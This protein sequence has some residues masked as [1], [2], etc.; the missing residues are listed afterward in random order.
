MEAIKNRKKTRR[1][2][3]CFEPIVMEYNDS[4][5]PG[6][7]DGSSDQVY[8]YITVG[9]N[10]G[11]GGE[12][13]VPKILSSFSDKGSN[14]EAVPDGGRKKKGKFSRVVRAV[15]FE[16]YLSKKIRSRKS[17][18]NSFR[19]SSS[20]SSKYDKNSNSVEEKSMPRESPEEVDD[21]RLNRNTS[22]S[23]SS[24]PSTIT[25]TGGSPSLC[26][27]CSTCSRS[28][29]GRK[30]S[31]RSNSIYLK[32]RNDDGGR[33]YGLCLL[34][35]SLLVLIF[36]GKVCAI[37]CT[38]TWLFFL[39][40][41]NLGYELPEYGGQSPEMDTVGYKKKIIMEGLLERNRSKVL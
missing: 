15:L 14:N 27:S 35:I 7:G 17:R 36:W 34:L 33:I 25:T 8:A 29:S 5:K 22:S 40:R 18:Q 19:S 26:A 2:F 12:I 28:M 37:F 24:H 21:Q 38:S 16:T 1:L 4:V 20:L 32:Q 9:K 3:L 31:P 23:S 39:P 30:V 6:R 11:G 41:R 13:M 10:K